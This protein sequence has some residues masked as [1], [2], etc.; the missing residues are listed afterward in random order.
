MKKIIVPTIV[1]VVFGL[2]F[3]LVVKL[4]PTMLNFFSS[5]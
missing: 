2:V 3:L 4:T 1:I 5:N